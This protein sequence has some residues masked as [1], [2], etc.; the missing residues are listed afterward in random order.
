MKKR[1]IV[2]TGAAPKTLRLNFEKVVIGENP[3]NK[4]GKAFALTPKTSEFS[5][6]LHRILRSFPELPGN[7][8][9]YAQQQTG[10]KFP[11]A[12]IGST[13]D[14]R[15]ALMSHQV[16]SSVWCQKKLEDFKCLTIVF[17]PAK[18]G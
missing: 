13:T 18:V 15:A 12:V 3:N 1:I 14:L 2:S 17:Q 8:I 5:I 11:I 10:T 7:I 4:T 9:V 6:G 16:S